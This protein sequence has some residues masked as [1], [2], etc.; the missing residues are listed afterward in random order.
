MKAQEIKSFILSNSTFTEDRYG[1][2][3]KTANNGKEYRLVFKDKVVRF[4]T[5]VHHAATDYSPA[6]KSWIKLD[7]AYYKDVAITADGRIKIG[8]K[9]IGFKNGV[10]A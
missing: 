7:G 5:S 8:K 4:E 3:R 1:N 10:S 9:L 6:S 2:L